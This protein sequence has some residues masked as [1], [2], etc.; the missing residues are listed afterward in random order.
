MAEGLG[1]SLMAQARH[2]EARPAYERAA[3]LFPPRERL[4][5][6]RVHRKKAASYW[7]LHDYENSESAHQDALAALRP[8]DLG[9]R[10]VAR[11]YIEIQIGRLEQ[12]YFSRQVGPETEQ[13]I[14]ELKPLVAAH[15]SPAQRCYFPLV[16]PA[17]S[18]RDG[19]TPSVARLSIARMSVPEDPRLLPTGQLALARL[20]V[21]FMLL[22][23]GR[24]VLPRGSRVARTE[25]SGTRRRRPTA[26]C[27]V[28]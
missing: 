7:M 27:F 26:P 9:V 19:G 17:S 10:D 25:R 16:P 20:T 4:A 22:L 23:G 8:P 28:A 2:G 1:D 13:L 5:R 11:E 3:A 24:S 18:L 21:G 12:L 14:A 6:A 15:A